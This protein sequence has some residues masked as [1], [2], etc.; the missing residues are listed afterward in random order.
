MN[1]GRNELR[2]KIKTID[3]N[4]KPDEWDDAVV[5]AFALG[6]KLG[7]E[8]GSINRPNKLIG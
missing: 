4:L 8:D 1:V 6:Y 2:K 7:H 5:G 3:S